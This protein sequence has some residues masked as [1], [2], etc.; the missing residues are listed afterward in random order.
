MRVM[1]GHGANDFGGEFD[2]ENVA[3]GFFEKENSFSIVRPIGSL[4]EPGHLRNMGR[5]MIGRA[6]AAVFGGK[7]DSREGRNDPE[8]KEPF[9]NQSSISSAE[10]HR[11]AAGNRL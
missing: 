2:L 5:Q 1:E 4:P 10:R 9:H 7:N 8:E 6:L 11:L 3:E